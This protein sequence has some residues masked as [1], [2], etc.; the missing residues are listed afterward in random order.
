M[1]IAALNLRGPTHPT[2]YRSALALDGFQQIFRGDIANRTT[3]A[4]GATRLWLVEDMALHLADD[5]HLAGFAV[6]LQ[7]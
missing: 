5:V 3:V 4:G 6:E 7:G 2:N 1:G